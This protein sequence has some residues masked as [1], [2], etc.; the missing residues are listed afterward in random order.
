[1]VSKQED[2]NRKLELLVLRMKS[3]TIYTNTTTY[4][5]GLLNWFFIMS[6]PQGSVEVLML[7]KLQ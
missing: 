4:E 7:V 3:I 6:K 2:G 1:M 5:L